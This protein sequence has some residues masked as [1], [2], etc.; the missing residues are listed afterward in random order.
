VKTKN[1][2]TLLELIFVIVIIGVLAAV[3]VPK[4][5]NLTANSKI[6][7]E[8]ATAASAQAAI[9]ACH[10]EWIVNEGAFTCGASISNSDLSSDGYPQAKVSVFGDYLQKI[11]KKGSPGW[12]C[13]DESGYLQCEGPASKS[14]S[15]VKTCKDDKPCE[16]TCWKYYDSNGSFE[17]HSG[18]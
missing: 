3:A 9:D 14:G 16:T 17:L 10:G 13:E 2:F 8:L 6:S 15:G 12:V 4:F 7:A 1:A 18:C 5:K 11:L